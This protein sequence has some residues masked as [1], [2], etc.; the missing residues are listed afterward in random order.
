MLLSVS[1]A[2]NHLCSKHN[3]SDYV[4][5]MDRQKKKNLRKTQSFFILLQQP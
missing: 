2:A 1:E 5:D 4:L 3:A